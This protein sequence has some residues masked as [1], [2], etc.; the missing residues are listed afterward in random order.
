MCLVRRVRKGHSFTNETTLFRQP[1][2]AQ[3]ST[4]TRDSIDEEMLLEELGLQD[5]LEDGDR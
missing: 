2:N 5:L 3:E 4:S 1:E